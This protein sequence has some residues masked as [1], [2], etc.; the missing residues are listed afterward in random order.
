MA[1]PPKRRTQATGSVP[2]AVQIIEAQMLRLELPPAYA[3]IVRKALI[4]AFDEGRRFERAPGDAM[5][6]MQTAAD[7]SG[8]VRNALNRG[9]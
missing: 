7:F 4:A 8:T 3:G 2:V 5:R 9:R 1:Q 6:A